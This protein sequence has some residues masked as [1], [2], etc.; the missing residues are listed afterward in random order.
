[1]LFQDGLA[2]DARSLLR[3]VL[4]GLRTFPKHEDVQRRGL[5]AV[6]RLADSVKGAAKLR[7]P[8]TM[9]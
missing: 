6:G 4:A 3:Q 5:L 2:R 8:A 9:L 1:M 7:N